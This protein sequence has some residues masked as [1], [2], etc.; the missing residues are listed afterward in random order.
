MTITV[1]IPDKE[2]PDILNHPVERKA[3]LAVA[4]LLADTSML[5][6][7]REL[8]EKVISGEWQIEVESW[9]TSRG[10]ERAHDLFHV[11]A[12]SEQDG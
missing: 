10:R 9:R 11:P 8:A 1:G 5:E 2:L 7:R 3:G 6:R 4:K 12:W